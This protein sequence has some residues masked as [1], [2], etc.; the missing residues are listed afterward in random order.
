MA[1][2][3]HRSKRGSVSEINH[4]REDQMKKILTIAMILGLIG[5]A[6]A[7]LIDNGGGL[8]YDTDL[9]ITWYDNTYTGT[10]GNGA[11]WDQANAWATGLNV[12]GVT[13]WRLP[14]TLPVN[15]S[16]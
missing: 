16:T 14:Q 12:G 8:I 5:T 9:N 11:N 6:N 3:M 13:G 7:T 2:I 1:F 4:A 10:Q 15:G